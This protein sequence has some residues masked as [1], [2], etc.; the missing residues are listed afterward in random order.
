MLVAQF[1]QI[2]KKEK[3]TVKEFDTRFDK[4]YDQIPA[5]L[6]LPATVVRVLHMNAFEGQFAF[7]LKD[8][9]PDTLG[10]AKE[11]STQIEKNLISSRIEPFQ[12]PHAKV[13]AKT[14]IATNNAP[15]P[16]TLLVQ[17]FDQMNAQFV[18]S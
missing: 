8:K 7:L 2:K 16:I 17:K 11:Y 15:N 4:P 14:K 3:E 18:Q 10:K 9:A 5:D 12:F 1:N 13:E 6:R